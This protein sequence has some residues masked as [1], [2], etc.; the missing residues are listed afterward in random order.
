[1][2]YSVNRQNSTF[3]ILD[4]E[5]V[6]INSETSYYYSLNKTGTFIWNLLLDEEKT[7]EEIVEE[8]SFLYEQP[9]EAIVGNI[10]GLLED[11]VRE[12]LIQQR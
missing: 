4:G 7:L 2:K 6:I 8:V 5:A 3:R 12:K 11:L 9:K 1:M 10:A